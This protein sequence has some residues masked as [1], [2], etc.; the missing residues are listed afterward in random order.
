VD[1]TGVEDVKKAC[2]RFSYMAHWTNSR[3]CSFI[4]ESG[5][6]NA[7]FILHK[8]Q[9][10]KESLI[11]STFCLGSLGDICFSEK[12]S[13]VAYNLLCF[14]YFKS[15]HDWMLSKVWFFNWK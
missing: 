5:V 9:K 10:L 1:L 6:Y 11:L 2:E 7:Y 8:M 4:A 15:L 12:Q 14:V 13:L 3:K